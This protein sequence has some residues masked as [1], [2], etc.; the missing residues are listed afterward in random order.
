MGIE[1]WAFTALIVI[2]AVYLLPFLVRRREMTGRANVQDRY[3]AELRVLATGVAAPERDGTCE[4]SGHAELFRRRPK[5]RAM[6]RPAVRNVRAVRVERELIHV[7]K[8]HD[9]A[10]ERRRV[11]ASHRAVVASVLLGVA[12][13]AWVLGLLTALPWWPALVPTVLLG[14]SMTAGRRA[15]MASAAADK[16][17]RRR[18]AELERELMG[19]TGRRPA[20]PV[21]ASSRADG[22]PRE[23]ARAAES[24][25]SAEPAAGADS[26]AVSSVRAS[27]PEIL[28]ELRAE[29]A[30]RERA[31]AS[32][33]AEAAQAAEAVAQEVARPARREGRAQAAEQR[34]VERHE[35]E[36][37]EHRRRR[38]DEA[39]RERAEA[40]ARA[41]SARGPQPVE[42]AESAVS[43]GS[44]GGGDS[45]FR[46]A[47]GSFEA[48]S[49]A[50]SQIVPDG[51]QDEAGE[52]APAIERSAPRHS[53]ASG[54]AASRLAASSASAA[55]RR[56]EESSAEGSARQA[57]SAASGEGRWSLSAESA[58][59]VAARA[60]ARTRTEGAAAQHSDGAR[61][62]ERAAEEAG[63]SA[64][65]A[66][67]GG[68]AARRSIK[69]EAL[70]AFPDKSV[71]KEPATATPPQ[72]WRPIK[73]PAPTY[74]LAARA[75]KRV[76]ADP[77]VDEG[78]SAPVPARPQA[79]RTFTA[80]DFTEQDFH[81]IDLDAI[82]ER[83]RAAGE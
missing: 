66:G 81:P 51:Q 45:E 7:R 16:R 6:N 65:G 12:L 36:R 46:S 8:T 30:E 15:A 52:G 59:S 10:R 53:T 71:V 21:V 83:R 13:G 47:V 72:G 67:A 42:P 38:G 77:V 31:R 9:Q 50:W 14:A 40:A 11:A 5:V 73:V 17:E 70:A 49:P 41:G 39:R 22:A 43:P 56:H 1:V 78:A 23:S 34:E 69:K 44:A 79:V 24:A 68:G 2:L 18:I 82:L 25:S 4:S 76:F 55:G 54:S 33:R 3:S 48:V 75:P 64:S 29:N 57:S 58:E 19:L 80:P 62:S 60:A 20:V 27:L 32:A 35:A 26:A 28:Q 63:R 37:E 61:P 74:T